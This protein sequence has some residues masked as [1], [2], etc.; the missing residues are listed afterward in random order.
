MLYLIVAVNVIVVSTAHWVTTAVDPLISIISL[1]LDSQLIV[2]PFVP[3]VCKVKLD[4][5]DDGTLIE[6]AS[7]VT[8]S[9]SVILLAFTVTSKYN[10]S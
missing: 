9:L 1:S 4:D 2:D 8:L 5:T 6:L 7:D 3:A 10:E